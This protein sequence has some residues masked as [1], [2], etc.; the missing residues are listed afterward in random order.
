MEAPSSAWLAVWSADSAPL[1]LYCRY[2]LNG[3]F[4]AAHEFL[5]CDTGWNSEVYHTYDDYVRFT[6]LTLS[7]SMSGLRKVER[8]LWNFRVY[9]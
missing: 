8:N 5:K 6:V 1:L 7:S 2:N 4:I 3:A 9:I